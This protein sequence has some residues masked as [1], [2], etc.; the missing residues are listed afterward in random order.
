[1]GSS[2]GV[3]SKRQTVYCGFH[4]TSKRDARDLLV[5]VLAIYIC[6]QCYTPIV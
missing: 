3:P 5:P 1:M 2:H 6:S 4:G